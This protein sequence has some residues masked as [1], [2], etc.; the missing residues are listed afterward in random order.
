MFV[1][2]IFN[3]SMKSWSFW[4]SSVARSRKSLKENV[5]GSTSP[6][7]MYVCK[8]LLRES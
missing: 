2:V 6:L 4:Y 8:Q 5:A 1:F 7:S 3:K